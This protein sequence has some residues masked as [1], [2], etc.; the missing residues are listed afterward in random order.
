MHSCHS[1]QWLCDNSQGQLLSTLPLRFGCGGCLAQRREVA[2][3]QARVEGLA[4]LEHAVGPSVLP[5]G[6][7]G[8]C[9]EFHIVHRWKRER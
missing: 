6:V 5:S 3:A 8:F 4:V 1:S 2:E 7:E 9:E